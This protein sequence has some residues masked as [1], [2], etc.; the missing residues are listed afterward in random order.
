MPTATK[1]RTCKDCKE[2]GRPLT[3]EARF[4]GPRCYSCHGVR[5]REVRLANHGRRLTAVYSIARA[6]Y[7]ALK[8]YQGDACAICQKAKGLKKNLAVDHDHA[9][10]VGPTSCGKCVRGLLCAP[11]NDVL[12]HFRDDADALE[13]A[14]LY[15]RKPPTLRMADGE[16]WPPLRQEGV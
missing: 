4:P 16:P 12:A 8:S 2:A 6:F 7:D 15:L 5:K 10:C 3:R 11:C 9:C 1:T 13:R 14:A